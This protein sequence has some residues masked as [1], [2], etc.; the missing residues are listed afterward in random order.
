M[1]LQVATV[2]V[3]ESDDVLE[4]GHVDMQSPSLI[5]ENS[6]QVFVVRA[7]LTEWIKSVDFAPARSAISEDRLKFLTR[8]TYAQEG[9]NCLELKSRAS[10]RVVPLPVKKM[11]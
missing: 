6:D 2:K 8:S 11:A 7:K 10:C 4:S 9:E 1:R 3:A 5:Q